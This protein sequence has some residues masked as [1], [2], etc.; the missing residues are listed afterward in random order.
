[1]CVYDIKISE[2]FQFIIPYKVS[3]LQ[4]YTDRRRFSKMLFKNNNCYFKEGRKC[5]IYND[6]LNT[7]LIRLCGIGHMVNDNSDS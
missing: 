6:A 3:C 7:L 1:M 5:L 2:N 4:G